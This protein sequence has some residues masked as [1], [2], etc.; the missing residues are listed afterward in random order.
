MEI[1]SS[2]TVFLEMGT[3]D[4]MAIFS[5]TTKTSLKQFQLFTEAI[6]LNKP[7]WLVYSGY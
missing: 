3:K 5:K 2:K 4:N 6:V 7:P 1:R